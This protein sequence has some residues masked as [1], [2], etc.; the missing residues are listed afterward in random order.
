[1]KTFY[2]ISGGIWAQSTARELR[3]SAVCMENAAKS[4]RTEERRKT[5]PNNNRHIVTI[6]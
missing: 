6:F 5:D 1:M 2:G 3:R 4:I